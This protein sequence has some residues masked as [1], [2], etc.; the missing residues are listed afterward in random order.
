MHGAPHRGI[1]QAPA[2]TW[3]VELPCGGEKR[4][5]VKLALSAI[6]ERHVFTERVEFEGGTHSPPPTSPV[7][8]LVLFLF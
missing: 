7:R 6:C 1:G 5:A 2:D 4:L 3:H 8:W